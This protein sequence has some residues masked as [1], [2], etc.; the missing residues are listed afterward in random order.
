MVSYGYDQGANGIGH[1]TS[2]SDQAGSASYSYDSLGRV[3]SEQRIIG[4]RRLFL[5]DVER[6]TGDLAATQ[7]INQ[8]RFINQSAARAVDEAH[9][10]LHLFNA[11]RVDDAAR[12]FGERRVQRDEVGARE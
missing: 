2:L 11:R 12:L 9:A 1:L 7:G 3:A 4:R 10:R 8:R 6:R 5:E